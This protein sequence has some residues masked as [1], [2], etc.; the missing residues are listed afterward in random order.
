MPHLDDEV[1]NFI[2][3]GWPWTVCGCGDEGWHHI[4]AE[5]QLRPG[6]QAP[7]ELGDVIVL[8]ERGRSWDG[9]GPFHSPR[10]HFTLVP[11][12]SDVLVHG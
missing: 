11:Y 3:V 9:E 6:L 4:V 1:A 2:W 5:N 7:V 10:L 12:H 8:H